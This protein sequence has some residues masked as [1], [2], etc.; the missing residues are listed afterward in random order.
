VF[1]KRKAERELRELRELCGGHQ[2][3]DSQENDGWIYLVD[4]SSGL[5]C[6][7]VDL[8]GLFKLLS[9]TMRSQSWIGVCRVNWL[10]DHILDS[11]GS[12]RAKFNQAYLHN[13]EIS[14]HCYRAFRVQRTLIFHFGS[15]S[16]ESASV[17]PSNAVEYIRKREQSWGN[18]M[19]QIYFAD[20]SNGGFATEGCT[21]VA[22]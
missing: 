4:D 8:L 3:K 12:E 14:I 10:D 2:R 15:I 13:R 22:L 9:E 5:I 21:Y 20:V 16:F 18:L 19:Y 6:I 1:A 7:A 17:M 11:L